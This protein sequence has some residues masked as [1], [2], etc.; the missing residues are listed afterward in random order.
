MTD[1][2]CNE[3]CSACD[4]P[5][6]VWKICPTCKGEGVGYLGNRGFV[7]TYEDFQEDPD[8]KQDILDGVY[9]QP[10]TH[11]RGTG[12][13]KMPDV[14]RM[15]DAQRARHQADL[16]HEAECWA[17]ARNLAYMSGDYWS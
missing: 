4:P 17:E 1:C 8:L 7:L 13:V 11:C 10:C 16:D 2:D 5:P 9:D 6:T 3:G 15:T 12:K 14:P